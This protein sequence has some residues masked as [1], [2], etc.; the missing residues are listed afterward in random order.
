MA[1]RFCIP[2]LS[3]D[4]ILPSEPISPTRSRQKRAR[5]NC[6]LW[7]FEENISKGKSTLCNTSIESNNA[8]P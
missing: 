3:S 5:F 6:S 8:A 7:L 4:G 1:T 2:P